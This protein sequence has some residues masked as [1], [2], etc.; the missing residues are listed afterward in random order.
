MRDALK[1]PNETF[2]GVAPPGVDWAE[3]LQEVVY[4]EC[5]VAVGTVRILFLV[6]LLNTL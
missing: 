1:M 6:Q 5:H 3:E 2:K 4:M